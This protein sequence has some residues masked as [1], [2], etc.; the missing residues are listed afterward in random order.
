MGDG[1]GTRERSLCLSAERRNHA[2]HNEGEEDSM[3]GHATSEATM[4]A[5]SNN[6]RRKELAVGGTERFIYLITSGGVK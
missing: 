6:Q 2:A 4:N 5:N 3:T 1:V